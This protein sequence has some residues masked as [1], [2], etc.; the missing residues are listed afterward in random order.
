[1]KTRALSIILFSVGVFAATPEECLDVDQTAKVVQ[2][3]KNSELASI[4]EKSKDKVIQYFSEPTKITCSTVTY[5]FDELTMKPGDSV[6][7]HVPL[8][9]RNRGVRFMVLGHRQNPMTN[10]SGKWDNKPGLSSVQVY[11]KGTWNYW[12]G[13]ASGQKGAKFAEARFEPEMENLYDWDHYGHGDVATGERKHEE[14]LPEAF[15]VESVGKDEVLLSEITLKISPPKEKSRD[16]KI[17]SPGTAFTSPDGKTKYTLGG[18][19]SHGGKFPKAKVIEAYDSYTLPIKAGKKIASI[20]VAAG[21]S[22]PDGVRNSD[23]GVGTQGWAKI[24]VGIKKPNGTV[25]WFL[26]NE[27]VPP[28]GLIIAS[29]ESCDEVTERGSEVVIESED[30]DLYVMGVKV[31]YQD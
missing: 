18:G 26:R 17:F 4:A 16:E 15:K 25:K 29:P 5:Q 3:V 11:S 12:L 9:L 19:Q 23:G 24:N 21:D 8:E 6:Y 13:Q 22:H 10:E 20:E 1:M 7:F 14:L 30:D 27:N 31:G 2:I 28:Q